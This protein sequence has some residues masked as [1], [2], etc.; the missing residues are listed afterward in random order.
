MINDKY[1]QAEI[2]FYNRV[3]AMIDERIA[4]LEALTP[5]SGG[6]KAALKLAYDD[7]GRCQAIRAALV[8]MAKA[9]EPR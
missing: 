3:E 4:H 9:T 6:V 7:L 1:T 2:D 8:R 5:Y